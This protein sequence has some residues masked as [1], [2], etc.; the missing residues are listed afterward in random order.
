MFKIIK[1]SGKL[2]QVTKESIDDTQW[3][4]WEII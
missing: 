3:N 1:A 4:N 2:H